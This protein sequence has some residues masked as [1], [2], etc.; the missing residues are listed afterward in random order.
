MLK[1]F[2][3]LLLLAACANLAVRAQDDF[4]KKKKEAGQTKAV[5]KQSAGKGKT[6]AYMAVQANH[7]FYLIVD[8]TKYAGKFPKGKVKDLELA[9]DVHKLSFE[10]ADST[11]EIVQRFIRITPDMLKRK[12][13]VYTVTFRSDYP[14]ILQ[15]GTTETVKSDDDHT[16]LQG[17]ESGDRAVAAELAS[18]MVLK[19]GGSFKTRS[20]QKDQTLQTV[21]V[22]S[23][24]VGRHEVTQRQWQAVM[25]YNNSANKGCPD[26][27]VEDVSWND[28][29]SFIDKL[30]TV[31]TRKFRLPTEPEW[32]YVA[33]KCMVEEGGMTAD[34]DVNNQIRKSIIEASAWHD[35]KG[36][37]PVG[38]KQ[39]VA[40]VFDLLGNVAEWCAGSD[41]KK[42]IKGGSYKDK[43]EELHVSWRSTAAP[44][45]KQRTVG[46][47]LVAD[48]D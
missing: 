3:L 35:E 1:K 13:S 20:G 14:D 29:R 5:Q 11:G 2:S 30:N 24:L 9:V 22:R 25:G 10:E 33:N 36:P 47:R 48:A 27:P 45:D 44:A 26:C 38:K 15:T 21:T 31:S 7:D 32:E 40:G 16:A 43:E 42:I 34:A 12:D 28:V 41:D 8:E 6:Y 4:G 39:A 23:L 46:F 19:N 37:H 18:D 17:Q